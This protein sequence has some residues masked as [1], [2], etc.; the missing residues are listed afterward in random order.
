MSNVHQNLLARIGSGSQNSSDPD[1]TLSTIET[2][3]ATVT[4]DN[5]TVA[6]YDGQ[7]RR[8]TEQP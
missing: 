3:R 2:P 4:A 5:R 1:A 7:T 8:V 6:G